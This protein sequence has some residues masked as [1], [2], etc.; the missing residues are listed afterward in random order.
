MLLIIILSHRERNSESNGI[1]INSFS[2]VN[3]LAIFANKYP[4]YTTRPT[5]QNCFV[6]PVFCFVLNMFRLQIFRV[7]RRRQS[8]VVAVHVDPIH[9]AV[10][11]DK[12]VCQAVWIGH[13]LM[14]WPMLLTYSMTIR[15]RVGFY[16]RL[17]VK[18][19]HL[20]TRVQNWSSGTRCSKLLKKILGRS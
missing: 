8:W 16:G 13:K 2:T 4:I 7:I 3:R 1:K 9:T 12:T 14:K 6:K 19:S 11:R 15:R 10:R 5:R 17:S 18:H 20:S